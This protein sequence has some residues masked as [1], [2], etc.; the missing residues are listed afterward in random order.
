M[1]E[2]SKEE[3]K[4]IAAKGGVNSGKA[5]RKKKLL[6]ETIETMLATGK[7][8]DNIVAALL[9]EAEDGNV[10]A[11][12]AIRDTIGQKPDTNINLDTEGLEIVVDYGDNEK[13]KK[14]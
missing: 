2:R 9:K 7:T 10:K 6:R 1:S 11:F 3:V 14:G 4:K 13:P 5:R 8:Q 12:E